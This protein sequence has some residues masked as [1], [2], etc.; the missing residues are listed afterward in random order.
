MFYKSEYVSG[1][2]DKV[3][4]FSTFFFLGIASGI[5]F[6]LG[7]FH[8]IFLVLLS[9]TLTL[10]QIISYKKVPTIFLLTLVAISLGI[11]RI[12]INNRFTPHKDLDHLIER[13][14]SLEGLVSNNPELREKTLRLEFKPD[15][16]ESKVLVYSEKFLDIKYGDRIKIRGKVL[17]IENF[18]GFGGR[19]F[20]YENYLSKDGIYYQIFYPSVDKTGEGYGTFLKRK[21]F[22]LKNF[23]TGNI[24]KVIPS[25]ED[26]LL[27]GLL[28]GEKSSF[29]DSLEEA[30]RRTGLVHIVVLS[31]YNVS[32]IADAIIRT[33]SFAGLMTSSLLAGFAILAFAILTGL[34]P[35]TLRA[36]IMAILALLARSTGRKYE[37]TRALF[38]AG[39]LM[40]FISPRILLYD[41]GF[42]LS[43]VA[44]LGL[45]LLAPIVVEKMTFMPDGLFKELIG[46]TLSTQIFVLPLLLYQIGEL[47]LIA[48]LANILVLPL[49]PPTMLLGFITSLS[50]GLPFISQIFGYISFLFLRVE[51]LIV[52]FLSD[53]PLASVILPR[54]SFFLVPI[55]YVLIAHFLWRIYK[56]RKSILEE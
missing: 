41:P 4:I 16:Y 22:A 24:K 33:V 32:I 35:A 40:V 52:T 53:I 10:G 48:P 37:I 38:L 51:I 15:D 30:F 29:S 46:A 17:P 31:G 8:A 36:S 43:F 20:D 50:A 21:L 49:I 12:D 28:F 26:L 39:A 7:L 19:V 3:I 45:I 18:E 34:G 13:E 56:K 44:T 23:F 9:L 47:S 14:V 11:F 27:T 54:F 25:P 2:A 6:N 42:Q 5:L 55:F 1:G